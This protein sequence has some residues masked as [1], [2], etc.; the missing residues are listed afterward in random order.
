MSGLDTT[1]RQLVRAEFREV[2]AGFAVYRILVTHDV[3]DALSM[4]DRIIELDHG[5][6]IWDGSTSEYRGKL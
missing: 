3:N 4:A 1:T 5:K 6:V 2:L